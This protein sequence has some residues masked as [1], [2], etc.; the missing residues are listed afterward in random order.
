LLSLAQTAGS[1]HGS[2][3]AT[4]MLGEVALLSGRLDDAEREL[5][6]AVELNETAGRTSALSLS[7][8][9]SG[10]LAL[11][12]GQR[13]RAGRLLAKA[14]RLADQT[15]LVSHLKVRVLGAKIQAAGN[16]A[17]ALD[18]VKSAEEALEGH[19]VCEPCSMTFRVSAA[20]VAARSGDR[21]RA[22]RYVEDAERLAGMWQ[23]GPWLAAVWEARGELRLAE[24]ERVQATALFREA[25]DG[26][27][28]AGRTMDESRCRLA[29]ER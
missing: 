21:E 13:A 25:A 17:R 10:E 11:A 19:E 4:L 27:A 5:G 28:R 22:L 9:R 15:T 3:L 8:Q 2:G 24:G 7:L 6:R 20:T 14:G 1:I 16:A 23:G 18:A 29:A 12:R 26:F